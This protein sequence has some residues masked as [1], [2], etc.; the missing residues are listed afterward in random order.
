MIQKSVVI[1]ATSS[2]PKRDYRTEFL[3]A[4]AYPNDHHVFFVTGHAGSLIPYV[5]I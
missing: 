3:N 5:E 1:I 2:P 4:F